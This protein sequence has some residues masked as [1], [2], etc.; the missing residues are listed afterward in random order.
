LITVI[1]NIFSDYFGRYLVAYGTG[2]ISVFPKFTTPKMLLHLWVLMKNHART[3][4]LQYPHYLGNTISRWERQKYVYMIRGNFHCVNLKSMIQRH[5]LKYT[6]HT[7]LDVSTKYPLP[8]LRCP[9]QMI[10][11]VIYSMC[12][13]FH[14]H[15]QFIT[16]L[17][18]PSAG[19]LFIPAHR[20]G[21][22]SFKFS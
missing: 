15:V 17:P 14:S 5:F 3:H 16:H 18:L 8:I 4:T 21:Y 10:F 9:Y 13:S 12:R 7:L 6:L 2:K 1:M 22:S 20:T 11:R 19:K